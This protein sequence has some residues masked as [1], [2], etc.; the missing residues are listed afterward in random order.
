MCRRS[1]LWDVAVLLLLVVVAAGDL[2]LTSNAMEMLDPSAASS[3]ATAAAAAAVVDGVVGMQRTGGRGDPTLPNGRRTEDVFPPPPPPLPKT[4]APGGNKRLV[5]FAGPHESDGRWVEEFFHRTAR[6][7][8]DDA[9]A[10]A[11]A[12]PLRGWIWPR[13]DDVDGSNK[14]GGK[15]G[16][17]PPPKLPKGEEPYEIFQHLVTATTKKKTAEE[18]PAHGNDD[19]PDPPIGTDA[20]DGAGMA[21]DLLRES[22][23]SAIGEAWTVASTGII[24]GT[25]AFDRG[26][27]GI[28]A[29]KKVVQYLQVDP[30]DV[31]IVIHYRTPRLDQW[32]SVYGRHSVVAALGT[33]GG[34]TANAVSYQDWLCNR[35]EYSRKVSVLATQMNPLQLATNVL[36]EVGRRVSILDLGG[37]Q[38]RGGDPVH[39]IA[40]N[41]LGAECTD[42]DG[43]PWLNGHVGEVNERPPQVDTGVATGLSQS[44]LTMAEELFRIRDC[45]FQK[46][47]TKM[48]SDDGTNYSLGVVVD[49][50]YPTWSSEGQ[51]CHGD[52]SHEMEQNPAIV[53]QALLSQVECHNDDDPHQN[54]HTDMVTMKQILGAKAPGSNSSKH[55]VESWGDILIEVV[56][57]TTAALASVLYQVYRM[58]YSASA[59][60]TRQGPVGGGS[61]G[62]GAIPSK[63]SAMLEAEMT[64]LTA[65][66][67]DLEAEYGEVDDD[68]SG[69]FVGVTHRPSSR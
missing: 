51:D 59:T 21:D 24:L 45:E 47:L 31:T 34:T 9:A 16:T 38:A 48:A 20:D 26:A 25:E 35:E 57:Y 3:S 23:Y 60:T 39:I 30:R 68:G 12:S 4:P 56:V 44:D 54:S 64:E 58:C 10:A 27:D 69:H 33:D 2:I 67:A 5:L 52:W 7:G 65:S 17:A 22:I 66:A 41:V 32:L 37:I 43:V 62:G 36:G 6:G 29:M 61:G 11:A 13:L 49:L 8:E 42:R 50:H 53:F 63:E 1:Y 55:P 18:G 14:G 46:D 19:G 28:E 40:C 15:G